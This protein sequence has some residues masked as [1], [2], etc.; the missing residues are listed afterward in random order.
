[1]GEVYTAIDTRLGRRVALKFLRGAHTDRFAREAQAIASLNHPHICTLYDVGPNY[2][3]MEHVEG[4]PLRG[5]LP[6]AEVVR[7]ALQI[8]GA[9]EAAHSKGV[10]H[11]DLKP[12]NILVTSLGVKLLDFGLAKLVQP[13]TPG[14]STVTATHAGAVLGTAAYMSPEQAEGKPIDPRSD[15]FSFGLVLY[16]ML[17][18]RRAFGG[19]TAVSTIAAILHKEPQPLQGPEGLVRVIGRCLRKSPADRFQSAAEV[20]A[21][22]ETAETS[23]QRVSSIAVL[24]FANMSQDEENDYFSDGLSEE[25]IHLL[26]HVP[27]LKVIARTSAFVF[28]G[29][30]DDIRTIAEKLNVRTVLEGSV[31]RSGNRI[32]VTAQLIDAKDQSHLWSERYDRQLTDIF[33]MQ[34]EIASAIASALQL[35]LSAKPGERQEHH[36]SLPAYEAYLKGLHQLFK[37]TPECLARSRELLEQAVALDPEYAAPHVALGQCHILMSLHSLEPGGNAMLAVRQEAR[38][39]L[40]LAPSACIGHAMLGLVAGAFDHDWVEVER[41][42]QVA[43]ASAPV[44]GLVRWPYANFCLGPFGRFEEAA[45]QMD[46]WLEEDPLNVA[47]RADLA[48]F[49]NHAGQ[50]ERALAAAQIALEVDEEYWF[51][52][53]VTSEIHLSRGQL[54]E[55]LAAAERAFRIAPWN[56]R[57]IGLLAGILARNGETGRAEELISR[58]RENGVSGML[59]YHLLASE[60]ETVAQWYERAIQD[61]ELFAI[62]Y[63]RAPLTQGLRQSSH[64]PSLARMMNLK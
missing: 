8:T 40:E 12:A 20:T 29:R 49:L 43:M 7:L 23:E 52:H 19:D 13:V 36:P 61:R 1:M 9:L 18:G 64:W 5:P 47:A 46:K 50:Y 59:V 15:I 3:V 58:I 34:D 53:Y 63:A 56:G 55:A 26:T 51:A 57:V 41:Q 48:F 32:R 44:P 16:E 45:E 21:A 54:V 33:S 28:K 22:L 6:P 42:F 38:K 14:D 35:K 11:R 27:G 31:R 10:I 24:P 17:S 37:N 62:L 25:I 30:K 2:L 39:T 4:K 60:V